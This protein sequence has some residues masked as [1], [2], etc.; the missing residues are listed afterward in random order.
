MTRPL[1]SQGKSPWYPLDRR[2]GGSQSWSGRGGEE[3]NSEPP[4]GIETQNPDWVIITFQ[5]SFYLLSR[6]MWGRV[7]I[8]QSGWSEFESRQ[9]LG[10]FIFTTASRTALGPTQPPTQ[11]VPGSLSLGVKWPGLKLTTHLH[12]VPRSKN[13]W[14]YTSTCSIRNHGVVLC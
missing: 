2:L 11:W 14:S 9:G 6:W 7:G 13:E 4:P 1:Y 5:E 12:L 8:A 3:K 10:I